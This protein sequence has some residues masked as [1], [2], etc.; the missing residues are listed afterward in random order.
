MRAQAAYSGAALAAAFLLLAATAAAHPKAAVAPRLQIAIHEQG[1]DRHSGQTAGT[2]T[3]DLALPGFA[4]TGKTHISHAPGTGTSRANA[5]P[6][7]A[8]YDAAPCSASAAW[9]AARRASGTR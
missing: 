3:I 5:Q 8:T 4:A 2:F 6:P 1:K 9:A 7:A